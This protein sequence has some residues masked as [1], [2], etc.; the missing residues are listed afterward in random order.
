MTSEYY[1]NPRF[2]VLFLFYGGL[3]F[4]SNF[5]LS[6]RKMKKKSENVNRP[7]RSGSGLL[8]GGSG[9][10]DILKTHRFSYI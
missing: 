2:E 9:L 10:S 3:V 6:G 5:G 4:G 8:P 7:C 1:I